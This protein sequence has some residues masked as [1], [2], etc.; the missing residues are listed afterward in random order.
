[1]STF[2]INGRDV[3]TGAGKAVRIDQPFVAAVWF[4]LATFGQYIPVA[5]LQVVKAGAGAAIMVTLKDGRVW[6]QVSD[7]LS[8]D[9]LV[10]YSMTSAWRLSE[11]TAM[12]PLRDA[13]IML[14]ATGQ[15]D[16]LSVT[17]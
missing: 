13:I 5:G 6:T 17:L 10:K 11:T 1:M 2:T 16:S 12:R 4:A 15:V 8:S 9:P 7:D 3:Y 14:L